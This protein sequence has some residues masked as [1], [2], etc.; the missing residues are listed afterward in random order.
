VAFLVHHFLEHSALVNPQKVALVSGNDAASYHTVNGAANQL[1]RRLIEQGIVPGDRVVLMLENSIA[2]VAA[3]YAVLKS[4]AVVVPLSIGLKPGALVPLLDSVKP[5]AILASSRAGRVL[6]ASCSN[7]SH[8][9]TIILN[10]RHDQWDDAPFSVWD[11]DEALEGMRAENLEVPTAPSALASIIFTSGSTGRPK[12]VML[13][14]GNIVSNTGA[15]CRSLAITAHDI[16]M[17]VLPFHYV[18]GA[19]LLNTHV[20]AGAR[21]VMNNQ[22]AYPAAVLK[23]MVAQAVT[24][25]AGVPSTYAYLLHR[26][27]LADA[28]RELAALRYCAQAGGHMPR[29]IKA[30][31]RQVLPAHTRIFIM[32]GATEAAARLTCLPADFFDQ[33]IDSIGVPIQ[34]V[35][36]GVCDSEG[37]ELPAGQVGELVASGPNIMQ[38]YWQDPESTSRVLDAHGRF[39]T[40]DLG[41]KDKEGFFFLI[42][43]RDDMI[44]VR[45]HRI[46]PREI[47]D[48]LVD[49]GLA[50]E[51][52][53]LGLKD[54]M[55]GHKICALVV[56]KDGFDT[57]DLSQ[58]LLKGCAACLPRFKLPSKIKLV[59]A[60]PKNSHG[61]I[62]R[63]QC[64]HMVV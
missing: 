23:E 30:R 60:L 62:D 56:P 46:A 2:F 17:V 33:K 1:A 18:M 36:I 21:I 43:R 38:G 34:G 29:P 61:K 4:G 42:G 3:Y 24:G 45:G 41:Y 47:E 64:L 63:Q 13:T 11:W 58:S 16:Q 20:A 15:I 49:T 39:H 31:L 14:H 44:K 32:Y 59:R 52:V 12:G 7:V 10:H 26:S 53:A 40:G 27:P 50:I 19:S 28:R 8:S 57:G 22:F 6:R 54:E 35:Q 55:Q 5:G 48:A 25:F 9:C 37:V 51:V